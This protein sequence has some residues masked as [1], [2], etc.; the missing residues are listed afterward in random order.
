MIRELMASRARFRLIN[1]GADGR[2]IEPSPEELRPT[3][4]SHMLWL[5]FL[6][7]AVTPTA[8]IVLMLA[9]MELINP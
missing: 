2:A 7:W 9:I 1:I 6:I 5:A 8:V 3:S 4:K